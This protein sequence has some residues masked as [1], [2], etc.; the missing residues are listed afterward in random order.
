M[1]QHK[2][3]LQPFPR[4]P[5]SPPGR[6]SARSRWS[7]RLERC[8]AEGDQTGEGGASEVVLP[9]GVSRGAEEPRSLP[10]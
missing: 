9:G 4:V 1:A 8:R 6:N 3:V 10:G 2:L 5:V 7:L